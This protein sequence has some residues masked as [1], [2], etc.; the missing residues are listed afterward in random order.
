MSTHRTPLR[1]PGGKQRLAPFVREV[2]LVNG[3]ELGHYVEPYAGGAGVAFEL[4]MEGLVSMIHLND[5]ALP[6]YAFWRSVLYQTDEL[7]KRIS[8]ATLNV[9]E[10]RM[11][12]TV[13]QNA[14]QYDE[15]DVG[16]STLYLN[17]TNRS[18]VLSG[19][20]IGGIRQSGKWNMD[21]RFPRS[22]LIRRIQAIA[23][24]RDA[25]SLSNLD[26]EEFLSSNVSRLP[27]NTLVYCDPP[28]FGH[29]SRL[30]LNRY[31]ADDH[32]RVARVVQND[33]RK[34]WI[35]SYDHDPQIW[36]YYHDRR[37]ISYWIRYSAATAYRG[38]EFLIFSDDLT[39]P[40]GSSLKW[41]DDAL[42]METSKDSNGELSRQPPA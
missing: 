14:S 19:G 18:G 11:H 27:T 17:R 31:K 38:R 6:I 33:L 37:Y 9:D 40:A 28:Y 15:I 12:R 26:A 10:W 24:R 41:I 22:E 7:C 23:S 20:S 21:A 29:S 3:L 34:R 5:I 35:V 39:I 36:S 32:A 2:I 16:Y 4:L 1:Y 30:Y 25:I 13:V 8:T 42:Q